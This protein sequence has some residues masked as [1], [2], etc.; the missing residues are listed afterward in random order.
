MSGEANVQL[1]CVSWKRKR[2]E[3]GDLVVVTTKE[4]QALARMGEEKRVEQFSGMEQTMRTQ[5]CHR[6]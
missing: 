5:L 4:A 1:L 6:K 3:V 2:A